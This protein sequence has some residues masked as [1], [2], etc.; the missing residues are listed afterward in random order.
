[1]LVLIFAIAPLETAAASGE[2]LSGSG[3]CLR[4]T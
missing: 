4:K 1:M 3:R 2:R